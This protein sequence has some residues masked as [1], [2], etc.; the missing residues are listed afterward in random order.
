[1][2]ALELLIVVT[3]LSVMSGLALLG[4]RPLARRYRL[5]E[6]TE[7]TLQYVN[8]AQARA[9]TSHRC[10]RVVAWNVGAAAIAAPGMPGDELVVQARP[11]AD[12][13]AA[14]GTVAWTIVERQR[15]PLDITAF[16]Y[17]D[18]TWTYA[19]LRPNARVRA[20][21]ATAAALRLDATE[22]DALVVVSASGRACLT[23]VAAPGPCP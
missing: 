1:M 22:F 4:V 2:T 9:R 14:P 10:H 11:T 8:E 18:A 23:T 13:E 16:N 15:L 5:R 3:L 17:D 7:L 6:A 21:A 12:C 19:E 20:N